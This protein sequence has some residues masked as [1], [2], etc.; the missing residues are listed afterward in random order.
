MSPCY[1]H[2][3]LFFYALKCGLRSSHLRTTF[4]NWCNA[5]DVVGL[6]WSKLGITFSYESVVLNL[7]FCGPSSETLKNRGHC[8]FN[9][10]ISKDSED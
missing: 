4:Q 5:L 3:L 2:Q 7:S 8:G 10:N 9:K 1:N 6:K